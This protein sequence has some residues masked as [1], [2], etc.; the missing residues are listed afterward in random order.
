MFLI[1]STACYMFGLNDEM[2]K[3]YID[4]IKSFLVETGVP[5]T[6]AVNVYKDRV[7]CC[8]NFL[9]G[10]AFEIKGPKIQ[11]IKDLDKRIIGKI[12]EICKRE[13]IECEECLHEGV[14][15]DVKG[16][17]FAQGEN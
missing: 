1:K 7:T 13:S 14:L 8:G 4:E 16:S 3:R 15:L 2:L 11:L 17:I 6:Y 9:F 10:V 12:K 5:E